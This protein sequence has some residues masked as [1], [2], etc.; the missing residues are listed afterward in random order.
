MSVATTTQSAIDARTL[1][2]R[3]ARARLPPLS[4][5]VPGMGHGSTSELARLSRA[6]RFSYSRRP[7][8]TRSTSRYWW[9]ARRSSWECRRRVPMNKF[10][11]PSYRR[12][13]RGHVGRSGPRGALSPDRTPDL[14]GGSRIHLGQRPVPAHLFRSQ[15]GAKRGLWI[16]TVRAGQ[17]SRH[18][19]FFGGSP[20][21]PHLGLEPGRASEPVALARRRGRQSNHRGT[22][23]EHLRA[24]CRL[25]LLRRGAPPAPANPVVRPEP[26]NSI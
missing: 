23:P 15:R 2:A 10:R 18:D 4:W 26:I 1:E 17:R 22:Q 3:C 21:P 19:S 16:A 13:W 20:L 7:S 8:R 24:L 14:V 9:M 25:P 11:A 12:A 5:H 6:Q